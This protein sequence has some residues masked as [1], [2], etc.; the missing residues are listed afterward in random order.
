MIA[1]TAAQVNRHQS[2]FK[3]MENVFF[4]QT[5]IKGLPKHLVLP[6]PARRLV[7]E[8]NLKQIFPKARDDL[9]YVFSDLLMWTNKT[10][11]RFKGVIG[12]STATCIALNGGPAVSAGLGGGGGSSSVS[13]AAAADA[14][15][16]ELTQVRE[17]QGAH[18]NDPLAFEIHYDHCEKG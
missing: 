4:I 10:Q 1:E 8:G 13:A 12:F 11:H 14:E 17:A 15:R 16:K 3:N 6:Q 18:A 5:I 2:D 7:M 9:F